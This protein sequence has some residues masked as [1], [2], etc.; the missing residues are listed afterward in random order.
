M[1]EE[2]EERERQQA[3][4][5]AED[6]RRIKDRES[7][8]KSQEKQRKDLEKQQ[9]E[10]DNFY[11]RAEQIKQEQKKK[12]KTPLTP[13]QQ[14]E[15]A[16]GGKFDFGK[17][18]TTCSRVL[19]LD[20]VNAPTCWFNALMMALFFSQNTRITIASSLKYIKDQRKLPIVVKISKLL[21]GYNKTRASKYLYE[22]LQ[23]KEFLTTLRQ[24]YP[25]QFPML[26]RGAK[27]QEGKEDSYRGDS[28]EYMHRMLQF[29]EIPHL[30]LSRPS[31]KSNRTEWSQYNYDLFG[32]KLWG[33]VN[34]LKFNPRTDKTTLDRVDTERPL[35][36]IMLVENT[37]D[38]KM[39]ERAKGKW[40][41]YSTHSV[42]GLYADTHARIITYN[43]KKYYLDSMIL[44]SYNNKACQ[45][46]HAIAGVTCN[47]G[48]FLYN[49]WNSKTVDK[50]L[51]RPNKARSEA[52]PLNQMDWARTTNFCINTEKC[53]FETFV[54]KM[55]TKTLCFSTLR[56]VALTYVREDYVGSRIPS[57]P[58]AMDKLKQKQ[59]EEGIFNNDRLIKMGVL[60]LDPRTRKYVATR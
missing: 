43:G 25:D 48:R 36:L 10:A 15:I 40:T 5:A 18:I 33:D 38:K 49:G 23:P 12:D 14:L 46:G 53:A 19:T 55:E 57:M 31:M 28:L 1:I 21:E 26:Q 54:S 13:M 44:G 39:T 22:R 59:T 24:F 42:G 11:R 27:F 8:K 58:A 45:K 9:K 56:N 3:R 7:Q 29:L 34:S 6:E 60:K 30:F 2:D 51:A 50:G 16:G 4:L 37:F 52:C 41:T 17:T 35:I 20:Q 32:N 47:G